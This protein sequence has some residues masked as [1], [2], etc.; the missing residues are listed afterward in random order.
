[1]ATLADALRATPHRPEAFG[2]GRPSPSRGVMHLTYRNTSPSVGAD[3]ANV[4]IDPT[5]RELVVG[6]LLS[7][8]RDGAETDGEVA[9]RIIRA[10][11]HWTLLAQASSS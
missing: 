8:S 10:V 7:F 9:E 4:E 2:L 11:L 1:V 5:L 3:I 6:E